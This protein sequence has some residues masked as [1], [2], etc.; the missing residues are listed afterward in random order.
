VRDRTPCKRW[1]LVSARLIPS[2][3]TPEK[4]ARP[5]HSITAKVHFAFYCRPIS[6]IKIHPWPGQT[7]VVSRAIFRD[8][9]DLAARVVGDCANAFA[10]AAEAPFAFDAHERPRAVPNLLF[11]PGTAQE[12]IPAKLKPTA[13]AFACGIRPAVLQPFADHRAVDCAGAAIG[14][15][16]FARNRR[17]VLGEQNFG[18]AK[19]VATRPPLTV[20][21]RGS[22]SGSTGFW[23]G[24]N[25]WRGRRRW[26]RRCRCCF[27]WRF[28][29]GL[30]SLSTA[31]LCRRLRGAHRSADYQRT[32]K[33][34]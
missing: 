9:Q 25:F 24:R 16:N 17:T 11:V 18:S 8:A 27:G 7:T 3:P 29:R 15:M 32:E 22:A 14:V 33:K 12:I 21:G 19:V 28:R 6:G 34:N 30:G 10:A 20:D 13:A 2:T 31:G 5:I 23:V 26:F 1:N 4:S